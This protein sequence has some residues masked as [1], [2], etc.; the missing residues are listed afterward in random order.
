MPGVTYV[1]GFLRTYSTYLGL[2]PEVII[3]EFRSRAHGAVGGAP[4]A[5][6]RLVRHRQAAQP[7]RPQHHRHRRRRLPHRPRGHL[8]ARHDERRRRQ[9]RA[10]HHSP[11]RSASAAR[12]RRRARRPSPRPSATAVPAWQKNLVKIEAVDGDCWMEVRRNNSTGVVLFSG[13]LAEG[14]QGEVQGQGHLDEPRR[15]RQRAARVGGQ[16]GRSSRATS[17]RGPSRSSR[18]AS[19]RAPTR[20]G[21]TWP[22]NSRSTW[23]PG[24]TSTRCAT[25]STWRRRRSRRATTSR[26]ASA[27]SRSRATPSCSSPTTTASSSRSSTCSRRSSCAARCRSRPSSTARSRRPSAAPSASALPSPRASP[28]RRPRR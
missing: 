13:T 14:R 26:R 3:G 28:T 21:S 8:R 19:S 9:R 10:H 16:E 15:S 24:R 23:S 2:D 5:V 1:K 12:R 7:P 11:A 4:R 17:A 18:G 20:R 25:P 22:R 27:R 6:R